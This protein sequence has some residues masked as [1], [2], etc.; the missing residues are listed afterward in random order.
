[1]GTLNDWLVSFDKN[2]L[3]LFVIMKIFFAYDF[4]QCVHR[5]TSQN[6]EKSFKKCSSSRAGDGTGRFLKDYIV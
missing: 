6:L 1:M 3:F 5:M 2:S 4:G